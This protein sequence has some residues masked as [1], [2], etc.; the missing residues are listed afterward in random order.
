MSEAIYDEKVQDILTYLN[1][2]KSKEQISEIYNQEWKTVYIY[3]NSKG[4]RWDDDKE[5]FVEKTVSEKDIQRATVENTKAA[6]IIRMFDVKH[7]DIKMI[8]VKQ[9]FQSVVDL[10]QYMK[11]QGYIWDDEQSN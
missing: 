11:S 4:F 2:G 1:E 6:Q 3:M 7:P 10:G 9:D 5:T 8:A